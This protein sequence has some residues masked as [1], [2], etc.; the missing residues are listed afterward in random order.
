MERRRQRWVPSCSARTY[1]V[2][3]SVNQSCVEAGASVH[4]K[5]ILA[6]AGQADVRRWPPWPICSRWEL[7]LRVLKAGTM[8]PVREKVNTSYYKAC[9]LTGSD[10]GRGAHKTRI[11]GLPQAVG[12]GLAGDGSFLPRARPGAALNVRSQNPKCKMSLVFR[13]YRGCR[14][15]GPTAGKTAARKMDYQIW[16]GPAMGAFNEWTRDTYP[17]CAANRRAPEVAEHLMQG[18]GLFVPPPAF[19][20]PGRYPARQPGS[21]QA[22]TDQPD[23]RM[24]LPDTPWTLSSRS[25]NFIRR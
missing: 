1:V 17:S 9:R 7:K 12:N 24:I 5:A 15:A 18:A 20:R 11:T 25:S 23:K 14:H 16:C 6:Q 10:P 19:A 8:F 22:G 13:W 21:L 2:T 4:T 3:G